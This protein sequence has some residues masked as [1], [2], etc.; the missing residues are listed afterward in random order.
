[1]IFLGIDDTDNPASGGTGRLA[2]AVG[3]ALAGDFRLMGVTRHQLLVSPQIPYTKN[4]SC[5][6]VHL[7][8]HPSLEALAGRAAELVR[9]ASLPGSDPGVCLALGEMAAGS[10]FGL[11]AKRELLTPDQAAAE[12]TATGAIL[13]AVGGDG[14]G[15][16]GALAG[17]CLAAG[18]QDGRFVQLGQVREMRGLVTVGELLRAGVREVRSEEG[19]LVTDGWVETQDK[20]RPAL[21]EGQPLLFV[22]SSGNGRW[23]ALRVE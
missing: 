17:V 23:S 22:R 2:R 7:E 18:G 9:R 19:E 15:V 5:N 1:M 11:R 12:A 21:R 4:N 13:L 6:V 14:S 8:G 10:D 16:I 3:A 20:V